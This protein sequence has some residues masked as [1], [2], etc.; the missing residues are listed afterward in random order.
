MKKVKRQTVALLVCVMA[1]FFLV[2]ATQTW[3]AGLRADSLTVSIGYFGGPYYEKKVF[4][5]SD[6]T[7]MATT[8]QTYTL[9]DQMPAV[10]VDFATGVPLRD[11]MDA[12]GIDSGSVQ[13]FH[14]RT[15][16]KEQGY[17]KTM[18]KS[19]LMDIP[20]YYYKELPYHYQQGAGGSLEIEEGA[21]SHKEVENKAFS[22]VSAKAT[23]KVPAKK[24]SAYKK[25][26]QSKGLSKK[27]KVRK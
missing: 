14:F 20:R 6:M 10:V 23:V 3:A 17:Y 19:E 26:F 18:T 12:A 25:L 16:D 13:K 4:S 5:T 15:N 21:E 22:G 9:I 27:A 24:V 7:A 8:R 2:L 11:L 1:A